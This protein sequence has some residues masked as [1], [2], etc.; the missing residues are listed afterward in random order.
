MSIL[1]MN[2][3]RRLNTYLR[4]KYIPGNN[5][6][7][8]II[9]FQIFLSKHIIELTKL[10]SFI[11]IWIPQNEIENIQMPNSFNKKI[12]KKNPFHNRQYF[13]QLC[14]KTIIHT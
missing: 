11:R 3:I 9:Y 2:L 5:N 10:P 4:F 7:S 8:G 12:W 14:E 13:P 6:F 1:T